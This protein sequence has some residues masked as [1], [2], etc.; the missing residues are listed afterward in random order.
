M[1]GLRW[2]GWGGGGGGRWLSEVGVR[3]LVNGIEG[4]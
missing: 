3:R 2:G 1:R 4:V